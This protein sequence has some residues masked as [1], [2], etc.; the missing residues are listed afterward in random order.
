MLAAI[1]WLAQVACYQTTDARICGDTTVPASDQCLLYPAACG[2]APDQRCGF[3]GTSTVCEASGTQGVNAPCSNDTQCAAGTLCD[4]TRCRVACYDA[5]DCGTDVTV[6]CLSI[7]DSAG[8]VIAHIC[9]RDCDPV[10]PQAPIDPTL[11][12]CL[13]GEACYVGDSGAFCT[14]PAGA[15]QAGASCTQTTDCASGLDCVTSSSGSNSCQTLCYVG[16]PSSCAGCSALTFSPG[17]WTGTNV[18]IAGQYTLGV[19]P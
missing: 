14:A 2:C 10:S 11:Q 19:C 9:H 7:K 12:T 3:N 18:V 5:V 17:T 16:Q 1:A 8:N 6:A 4:G 15:G 13:A